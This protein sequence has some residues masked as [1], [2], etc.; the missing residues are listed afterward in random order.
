MS[1]L[2]VGCHLR[3][4]GQVQGVGFRPFV[5]NLATGLGLTGQVY[6]DA[7]GVG[8]DLRG[9]PDAL[10]S[11]IQ[12]LQHS[13]PPMAL[14]DSLR[15]RPL[16]VAVSSDTFSILPSGGGAVRVQVTPDAAVCPAC[17]DEMLDPSD[18]RYRYPF[19]NCTHCGPRYSIIRRLPYDRPN[20]SMAAFT[21]C[22]PCAAEY[23][24]PLD[25]RF[26]AQP[27]ACAA[28]G[29]KLTLCDHR[30]QSLPGDPVIE[31]LRRLQQGQIMAIK[32][33]G[34]FHLVCDARNPAAVATLRQ[35]KR[36][37]EKPFAVMGANLAS[38]GEWVTLNEHRTRSLQGM[39][40]PVVLCPWRSDLPA[41]PLAGVAP[42][43]NWCG[44][45]LPHTPLH[46]L[47][48]HAAAG[49]P[50]T[51]DWLKQPQSLLLV[52]T[53]G[54]RRGEP[55]VTDNEQ[56]LQ[57]LGP[58][59][60]ALLLHDRTIHTR[61]DD[62]VVNGV[63]VAPALIRRARGLSPQ[64]IPLAQA[65]PS[66]LACGAYFKNSIC[67]TRDDRAYVSPYIG[68][69]DNAA[70]CRNLEQ[71]VEHLCD[72]LQIEPEIVAHDLHEDFYSTRFARE[73]ADAKG[74][75]L[76]AVQHHQAHIAA[77]L[78]EQRLQGPVLGLA[79]DGLGLG[80]DG[81]LW[82]GELL[83]VEGAESA[84]LAHLTPLPL[85]GGDSAAREP[86]R[87]AAGA[88]HQM[89]RGG[90]II[91]RFAGQPGADMLQQ[92]L[93]RNLNCPSSSSAGRLFDAAA[94]LLGQVP[95]AGFEAQAAMRL[96][97]LALHEAEPIEAPQMLVD[98]AGNLDPLPL[99][100]R[101][102][103]IDD[104]R[105]GAALFHSQLLQ[106]LEQWVVQH[107]ERTG[108]KQVVLA[109][110]CFLNQRLADG[111]AARLQGRGLQVYRARLLPCN[112]SGISL[113][114]AWVA[115]QADARAR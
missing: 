54:N 63:G 5:Y 20:T 109:G 14:I 46:Y 2:S 30:G 113:G 93:A 36:R 41:D 22:A 44:V 7:A 11:F 87:M 84:R 24:D 19:I 85:P 16:S 6:N 91:S 108:L 98:A 55:L 26:H 86:W 56:A 72:L 89:G 53:S 97:S 104:P 68:D 13:P 71:T 8:I 96:E 114:Q 49:Q 31:T 21:L 74:L 106:G 23:R 67:L 12:Q 92:M 66:V 29:P 18:R 59:V 57:K 110:G 111:L 83:R 35:R 61:C 94:G 10:E 48:F 62:S 50:A 38:L 64:A 80:S 25:R 100:A 99:L 4:T 34:G 33:V 90:E 60:D 15:R 39:D 102:L 70:C 115:L 58:M 77:V 3:V 28:C 107:A 88:L 78:A 1:A 47:L 75:V 17:L 112:D 81:A 45:M 27:T 51:R 103:E 43:L 32:G 76:Q 79:L 101:L 82:G 105:Y 9:A 42:G 52:M 95:V 65:G 40:A 37:G 73:F 69:L